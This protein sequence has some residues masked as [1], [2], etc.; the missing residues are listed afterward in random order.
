MND[1]TYRHQQ[2]PDCKRN[3]DFRITDGSESHSRQ[4]PSFHSDDDRKMAS[5]IWRKQN[6][7]HINT[8]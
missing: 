5:R 7:K 6:A 3:T 4:V 1:I 2:S 8:I